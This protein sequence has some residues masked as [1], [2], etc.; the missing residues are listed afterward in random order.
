MEKFCKYCSKIAEFG[1]NKQ[2][3][4]GLNYKCN[5][6]RAEYELNRRVAKFGIVPK[7]KPLVINDQ[8]K[9]CLRCKLVLSLEFFPNA[10]RG[11][12]GKGPYCGDC[13]KD[14]QDE[15]K[16]SDIEAYRKK[17]RD[18]TQKY[19]DNNRERWRALHRIRQFERRSK[20]KV[21]CD[22]T[23]TNKFLK[24][25]YEKEKCFWCKK[26]IP[27]ELRTA[28]HIIEL[29]NGGLHSARNLTMACFPCNSS[30][31]NKNNDYSED[32]KAL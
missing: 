17:G 18:S 13:F 25:L 27:R 30:R 21:V 16:N 23:V 22:G 4:D 19:R 29:N 14:Y 6:C 15:R 11:R 7:V 26:I 3:A 31:L 1:R 5:D 32:S 20:I 10:K 2:S 24:E 9:E 8:E 28:E 12:H